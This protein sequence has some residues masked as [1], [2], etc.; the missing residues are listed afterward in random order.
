MSIGVIIFT[1]YE[2]NYIELHSRITNYS[3]LF[4]KASNFIFLIFFLN[5]LRVHFDRK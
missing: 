5:C 4:L 3:V 1:D 2:S